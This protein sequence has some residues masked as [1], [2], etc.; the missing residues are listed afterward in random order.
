MDFR[1]FPKD[2]HRFDAVFVII[3]RLTKRPISIPCHKDTD[4]KKIARLFINNMIRISGIPS[5]IVS[6]RGSQFVS[7]F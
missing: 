4:T 3:D 2:R 6:D 1:S 5:L 7:E